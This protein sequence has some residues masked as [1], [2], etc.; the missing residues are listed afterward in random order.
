MMFASFFDQ[1]SRCDSLNIRVISSPITPTIRINVSK[2]LN[3]LALWGRTV[4][5]KNAVRLLQWRLGQALG[6]LRGPSRQPRPGYQN[7]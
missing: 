5:K 4:R 2:I 1:W 3:I 7:K 6:S